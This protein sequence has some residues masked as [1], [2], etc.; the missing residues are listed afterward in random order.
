[1]LYFKALAIWKCYCRW[2]AA[3]LEELRLRRVLQNRDAGLSNSRKRG[4]LLS[5]LDPAYIAEKSPVCREAALCFLWAA[6]AGRCGMEMWQMQGFVL[7]LC[8]VGMLRV[9][10]S[11]LGLS[12]HLLYVTALCW[13]CSW[14]VQEAEAQR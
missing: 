1:M 8:R 11:V 12:L 13:E 4:A 7:E 14:A 10:G 3:E 6:R 2:E 5:H 9:Q